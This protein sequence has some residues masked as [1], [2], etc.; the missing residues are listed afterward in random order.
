MEGDLSD[1]RMNGNPTSASG[2]E[3]DDDDADDDTIRENGNGME[4]S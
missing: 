1:I 2:Y 3:D 4:S